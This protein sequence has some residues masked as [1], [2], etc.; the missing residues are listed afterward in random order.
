MNKILGFVMLSFSIVGCY[1]VLNICWKSFK[2]S[3][4]A[5]FIYYFLLCVWIVLG[6][7]AQIVVIFD[8]KI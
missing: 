4:W 5:F 1:I 8:M 3:E 7:I 6:V 2:E